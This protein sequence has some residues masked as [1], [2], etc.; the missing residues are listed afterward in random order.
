MQ[1]K[2][3]SINKRLDYLYSL[4]DN[5]HDDEII[6]L[7]EELKSIYWNIDAKIY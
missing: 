2:I 7:E 1:D 5:L 4:N 3:N 6:E